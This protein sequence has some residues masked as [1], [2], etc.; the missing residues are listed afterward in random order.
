MKYLSPRPTETLYGAR[1]ANVPLFFF[2]FCSALSVC[3]CVCVCVC[4]SHNDVTANGREKIYRSGELITTTPAGQNGTTRDTRRILKDRPSRFA[5]GVEGYPPWM[6]HHR[7]TPRARPRLGRLGSQARAAAGTARGRPVP[8]PCA[9]GRLDAAGP[10][11]R[12]A[13]REGPHPPGGN[14]AA[15]ARRPRSARVVRRRPNPAKRSPV[16]GSQPAAARGA[17]AP[18]GRASSRA[19]SRAPV[20]RIAPRVRQ[21]SLP[22]VRERFRRAVPPSRRHHCVT[23]GV[24]FYLFFH[25]TRIVYGRHARRDDRL[26]HNSECYVYD[27]P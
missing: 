27:P 6:L 1:G 21:R 3:V 19:G 9:R 17:L 26:P 7:K 18:D 25:S 13:R 8:S 2:F 14:R 22:F 12:P 5:G 15:G 20:R 4:F 16:P 11:P 24:S 23:S 10:R